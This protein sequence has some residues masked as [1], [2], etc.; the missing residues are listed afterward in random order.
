MRREQSGHPAARRSAGSLSWL[1][2]LLLPVSFAVSGPPCS[3]GSE[4]P[5]LS[6]K[7]VAP[8][9]GQPSNLPRDC[10][11][12]VLSLP[13]AVAWALQYNPELAALRQQ[14]GIA[15]AG[16]VIARTYPYNPVTQSTLFAV[17]GPSEAGISNFVP[18]QHKVTVDVEVRGQRGFREQVAF[19]ALGRAECEIASQEVIFAVNAVR[20]FDNLLYRQA[21]LALAEEFLRLNREAADQVR[22]LA[23]GGPLRAADVILART[24]VNDVQAQISLSRTALASARR[25]LLRGLG[26]TEGDLVLDGTLVRPSPAVPAEQLLAQALERRPDLFARRAAVAEA[27][28]RVRLQIADRY[29]NPTVGPVFEY[30]ETRV[31]FLG[32]Q[33]GMPLPLFNRRTGEIQQLRAQ[34]AQAEL[35]LRRAEV[36]IRQDVFAAATRLEEARAWVGTYQTQVLPD[37]RRGVTEMERLFRQGQAGADVLRVQDVR[38]KLLRAQDGYLDALLAYTQALADVALAVGDPTLALCQV[39]TG[40]R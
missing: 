2:L 22:R 8:C 1:I 39:G 3:P 29:G 31:S 37:L 16:V 18:N 4:P 11:P 6:Q 35:N 20:A 30:N 38:R 15:A 9:P 10:L 7:A 17:T 24:E 12:P 27:E 5:V 13:T 40:A 33:F 23:Q 19:A 26:A 32:M 25:D 28:A 21:K 36:E 14:R 34:Q